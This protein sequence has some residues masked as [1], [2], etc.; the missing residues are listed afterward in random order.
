MGSYD[1][2]RFKVITIAIDVHRALAA[3]RKNALESFS[4]VIRRLIRTATSRDTSF[5][6]VRPVSESTKE[7][8]RS[9]LFG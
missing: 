3:L 1:H 2:S 4:D 8:Y 5:A 7:F 9:G 6:F